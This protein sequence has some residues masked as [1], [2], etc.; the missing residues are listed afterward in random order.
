MTRLEGVIERVA[1]VLE[2]GLELV[3]DYAELVA[4]AMILA[5]VAFVAWYVGAL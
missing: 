2:R 3:E 1:I 5:G 4:L